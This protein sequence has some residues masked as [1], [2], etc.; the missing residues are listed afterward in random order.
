MRSIGAAILAAVFALG[1]SGASPAPKAAAGYR[2]DIVTVLGAIISGLSRDGDFLLFSNLADG[3]LYRRGPDGAIE[4]FGPEFPHGLDVIGDPTGPYRVVRYGANYLVAQG[5]TP[6]NSEAGPN[7]HAL[8]EVDENGIL[9]VLHGD[10]WNPFN[11]LITGDAIFI[12]DAAKN[13]IE[14]LDAEGGKTTILGL[15]RLAASGSAMQSLSPTEFSKQQGYE[16]DAVPTGIALRDGRISVSLFG[17]FPFTGQSGQ[18]IS[19]SESGGESQIDVS[20]LDAPVDIAWKDGFLLILEHGAYD[21]ATGFQPGTGRLIAFDDMHGGRS[22]LLDGLTRPVSVLV[23]D[24][25]E[26]VVSELGGNLYFLTP[27][28]GAQ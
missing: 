17:G 1:A 5:W 22:V 15:P 21:Q 20:G 27:Q 9:G 3:R 13:T 2:L 4:A 19:F 10:F 16:F 14:W 7:D 23:W 18:V 11:F 12:V 28:S 6:T 25:D 24:D 26:I 8:I